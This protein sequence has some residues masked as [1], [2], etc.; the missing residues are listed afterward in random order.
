MKRCSF[1]VILILS[2]YNVAAD[3]INTG[4]PRVVREG[5]DALLTCVVMGSYRNDTVIWRKGPSEIL[6]AGLN[7]VTNDKRIS[8][9]HDDGPSESKKKA[10]G[11]DVWVLLIKNVKPQ[12]SDVYVCEVNSLPVIKSFH[13]LRIKSKNGTFYTN[14]SVTE[15]RRATEDPIE[16]SPPSIENDSEYH[17][18]PLSAT[19]DY[20]ECCESF[21]V[22]SKCLGFCSIHNILDGTT[23]IDPE[24]CENDFPSIIKCMA[25]GR[26]H[27]PCCEK[28]QIPD[29]C[30]DM[31]RGEYT[32]FTDLL[33]SRISC[34]VHTVPGLECILEGVQNIPSE[35]KAVFVEPLNEKSLQISWLPPENL[36]ET[37]KNYKINLTVLQSFDEDF[38]ANS[39]AT[40]ISVTVPAEMNTTT[41]NNLQPFTMYSIFVIAEN[42]FG[43]SLPSSR[44]RAL[45]LKNDMVNGGNT[46][47][48]I[49]KLPDVRGCCVSH[50]IT[51]RLCLDKMCDPINADFT[52][53]P[54]LMVCA[55]WANITFSC[56]AN[57]ID[58]TPCC[59]SR[60]MP[61]VC[62][63][64]CDGTVKTINFNSFK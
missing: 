16:L 52:E 62:L 5:E 31:C 15:E 29:L 20:T 14:P 64:F 21:N 47:A 7:R 10:V 43:S 40:T 34:A 24:S 6:S 39:T 54:D 45:T 48:V 37:V 11:G 2:S 4:G 38:L 23:G 18:F 36:P 22:S 49:P 63:P 25:D 32:P 1:V 41:I 57:N 8:V 46:I 59:K 50:G 58:H 35:P 27:M 17:N 44:K 26:N 51:H 56:L 61:D 9:L 28:K 33:R 19:H 53:V 60:G 42:E 13:P 30:Q 55:P 3:D 12:D